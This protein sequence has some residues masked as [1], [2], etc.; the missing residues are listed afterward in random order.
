MTLLLNDN[1]IVDG[2]R[3]ACGVH[4][5]GAPLVLIH[6]TPSHSHIWRNVVPRLVAAGHRHGHECAKERRN[7][8]VNTFVANLV[9]KVLMDML[10]V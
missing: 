4:G 1:V 2:H 8:G 9:D 6:G 3:I 10:M 5:E 7:H